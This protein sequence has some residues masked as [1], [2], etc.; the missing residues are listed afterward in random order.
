MIFIGRLILTILLA[1]SA[2]CFQSCNKSSDNQA[3]EED[4][5][6]EVS[7][8]FDIR[9]ILSDKCL[10]CHGPDANKREAG[11]RLDVAE[12][13]FKALQENPKAHA[14]VAGKPELSQ[15]YLRITTAD[16]ALRMPPTGSNLKLTQRE[17]DLIEKWIKQGAKYEKHWAF[18]APKKP[19]LPEVDDKDWP[20]N[21][22]DY[23]ILQKQEQKGVKPN[24]EADKERLLKRL[25]LDI[26]GLPPTLKMMDEFMADNSANAYEKMVDQ[27]LK[28]PAYGEKMAI[29]WLDLA[30]YADS[31]GY[32]D[33][34]YRT[35]W[36]WRDWVIHAFNKNM[37][38]NDFVT[39]QLAG[40]LLP[41]SSK[42]QLLATG[43]NRNH[44][45]TEE[46]GVI[47]EEYR[48]MYVTD[49]NDLFG[50]G[51]LGV[52]LECAHCHDHKYDPFS[53]KEYYQMF[54]FFNNV[55]EVGIESVIGGPE[56]YAKKPLM[57]ISND[58]VKNIL[59]FINKPDTNRLIVSVMG[60]LDTLRKTHILERGVYDAL[61]DEVQ[62]ATPTSILPFD[63]SYPKN[64]LGL[65]KW[66]FDKRNPLTSR[67]YV[68]ILW[69]EFFGKGIVKTSGDFGM[70][71]ELPSH[72]ALLDWLAT[73]FIDHGW[74]IKRL[75]KQMVTS[76]TYKQSAVVTKEKLATDPD[77]ILLAR[78]PRY[79]IHA[80]FI[81]DLVLASSG[82][83]NKTIGG[84]SVKP[85]QPAGLWEGA[86]SGRGLLSVYNQDHGGAL[87]RRG[88]YTLIKRTVPP[89]T[90]SIFDAS[91]RDLC[92]VKR[93]KTNTPLQALVMM[94]D[95]AVLEASRVLAA[96]LLQ[97][98]SEAKEK[99]TK[100]FRLIVCR[101][102]SDKELEVLS[103]YYDKQLQSIKPEKAEKMVTVGE[104]PLTKKVDKKAQAALMRVIST[105]YNLE[106]TITKS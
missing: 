74:D 64:R 44:K 13:A 91:N 58:D 42:E 86:T 7:Y 77:N 18:V 48:I 21:E 103:A 15:V 11:L 95:P 51:L 82:L 71:G 88:M 87:Y 37:H 43:F 2:L 1:G 100:A 85:Y 40:D 49:R 99:I 104:Y 39:W 79:R 30:R 45:I 3:V 75:V 22:I 90:M 84:P 94:N 20:K 68:N 73:D 72:P 102:P 33:D 76:A 105:I 83:L 89:P 106:E 9:P 41:N 38:Y 8:N 16:T 32:Q 27:L 55:K 67:V 4:I 59:T 92:E 56:T 31:H 65:S 54:A 98:K 24:E 63:K 36:P 93:L 34:G 12:D 17:V 26:T 6:K 28:N 97:E 96:K 62:P 80:E 61:G 78:G 53:Q 70:Q 66:L 25:S 69:Q 46:G 101:K 23:F 19:A 35:Q 81:K 10:A 52:T 57:E 29:H 50:K 47:P 60:D 14:L 5:P